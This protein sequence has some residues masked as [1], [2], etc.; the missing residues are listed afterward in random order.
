M[1]S[2]LDVGLY[3]VHMNPSLR[4]EGERG[5]EHRKKTL[6]EGMT[7]TTFIMGKVKE[8]KFLLL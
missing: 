3:L 2:V 4:K 7:D 5:R 6:G 1:K 8:E